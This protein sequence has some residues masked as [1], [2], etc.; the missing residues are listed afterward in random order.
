LGSATRQADVVVQCGWF[1]W[2]KQPGCFATKLTVRV[3]LEAGQV[4]YPQVTF[5]LGGFLGWYGSS[6]CMP[7]LHS[8]AVFGSQVLATR[9][10]AS[11]CAGEGS[12]VV[13]R[14][15]TT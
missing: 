7:A 12:T 4:H 9:G 11:L 8:V 5:T 10:T 15:A 1:W 6:V 14:S 13:C 3:P 2:D